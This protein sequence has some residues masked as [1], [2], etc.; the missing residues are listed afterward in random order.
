MEELTLGSE[1]SAEG[2]WEG[3]ICRYVGCVILNTSH[4]GWNEYSNKNSRF[5]F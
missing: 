5:F 4:E 2:D 3:M 1:A